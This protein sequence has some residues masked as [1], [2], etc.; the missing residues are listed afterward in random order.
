MFVMKGSMCVYLVNEAEFCR[1]G[2]TQCAISFWW[3]GSD[4]RNLVES[5]GIFTSPAPVGCDKGR[6]GFEE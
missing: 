1:I 5:K 4:V 6:Y 2:F 3:C